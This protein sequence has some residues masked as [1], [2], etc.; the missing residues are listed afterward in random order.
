MRRSGRVPCAGQG[1]AN[2]VYTIESLVVADK[3]MVHD[4]G[5]QELETYIPTLMNIVS[6]QMT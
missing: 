2:T 4:Y 6:T 1:V 3:E 5:V